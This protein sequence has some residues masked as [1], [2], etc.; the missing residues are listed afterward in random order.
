[1]EENEQTLKNICYEIEQH[2]ELHYIEIGAD[3]D[4]IHFLIQTVP[5]MAPTQ[6]VKTT[7]HLTSKEMFRLHPELKKILWGGHLWTSGFYM[8][9]VGRHGN[10]EAIKKYV[11]SQGKHYKQIHRTN[12][13]EQL[14]L[15]S[16]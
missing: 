2:Y 13:N 6:I 4:H 16:G 7:K 9:T 12:L 3:E 1:M 11:Q 5:M 8:N 10:E 14:T 15:F